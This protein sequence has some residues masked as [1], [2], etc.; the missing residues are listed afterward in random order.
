MKLIRLH[1]TPDGDQFNHIATAVID[2]A[3]GEFKSAYITLVKN[4]DGTYEVISRPSHID[5]A[6][7][8]QATEFA[9]NIIETTLITLKGA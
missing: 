1:I 7:L 5:D 8:V 2:H 4:Q 6:I 3:P 9:Q